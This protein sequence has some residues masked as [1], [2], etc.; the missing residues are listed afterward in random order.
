[1]IND[2]QRTYIEILKQTL[3]SNLLQNGIQLNP[4]MTEIQLI[5]SLTE[6]IDINKINN[7]KESIRKELTKTNMIITDL[8]NNI[9]SLKK[10][11]DD[12]LNMNTQLK[13]KY[14]NEKRNKDLLNT[15]LENE[16]A[17]QKALNNKIQSLQEHNNKIQ[18][19]LTQY[20]TICLKYENQIYEHTRK[21]NELKN[22]ISS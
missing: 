10:A 18:M 6:I 7:E 15:Q 3:Q 19:N 20:Q 16:I 17:K 2:K 21:I 1:M 5:N 13:S 8:K 14:D 22:E 12:I 11:N 9:N 4:S